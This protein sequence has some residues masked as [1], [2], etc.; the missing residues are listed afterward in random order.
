MTNVLICGQMEISQEYFD[1]FYVPCIDKNIIANATFY[2]GCAE[3][4]DA[5]ATKYLFK[6]NYKKV[7]IFGAKKDTKPKP[8]MDEW[9]FQCDA[10]MKYPQR[11]NLMIE[12]CK[13]VIGFVKNTPRAIGSGTFRNI[14]AVSMGIKKADEIQ[15]TIRKL[16]GEFVAHCQE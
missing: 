16:N 13:I 7:K 2:I 1:K 3:G 11:D 15:D 10:N 14:L 5:L 12:Q 8:F 6:K 9:T 4:C